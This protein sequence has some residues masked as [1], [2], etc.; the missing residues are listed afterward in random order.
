MLPNALSRPPIT[1]VGSSPAR[2][3]TSA[4]IE[5]VLVLPCAPATA[6]PKRSRIS[7]ASI[8]ARGITGIA[9]VARLDSSGLSGLDRR[10][11]HHDVG[12]A[13]VAARDDPSRTVTPSDSQPIRHRPIASRPIPTPRSRGSRAVRRCRSCR[14]RRCRRSECAAS[15]PASAMH[16]V[17][18]P[19]RAASGRASVA[20]T[21]AHAVAP[22]RDRCASV[23]SSA[24]SRSPVRPRS[25]ITA[26]PRR[27]G[28]TPRRS[29]ADDRRRRSAAAPESPAGPT[30]PVPTAS[31]RPLG[32]HHDV[33]LLHLAVHLVQER[34]HPRARG[35]P[36]RS[37]ADRVQIAL[38][39]LMGDGQPHARG[40][41]LR[42]R[43]HHG[44][45]DRVRAL[46]TA[47]DQTRAH[48]RHSPSAAT[49]VRR[50]PA[51]T[52]L[53]ATNPVRGKNRNAS[54]TF[55]AAA[56]TQR[57]QQPVRDARQR[58]LLE[59]QRRTAA[60]RGQREDRPRREA[61]D[62]D[63]HR[64]PPPREHAPRVH[65][66]PSAAA[67]TRATVSSATCP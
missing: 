32:N 39:R 18:N 35:L 6:M 63:H 45:V 19:L 65:A 60:Q 61:A 17:G 12:V 4:I 53:P 66:P 29:C 50:T 5:V 33:G 9:P 20:R 67:A 31:S 22:R 3:S 36:P 16:L 15:Y 47:N 62:P 23:S 2:S 26:P 10:R 1:A 64:R 57:R 24:A 25:S 21:A 30:P 34:L 42:R 54:G 27:R 58:V 7:S 55:T 56:R 44:H 52:G 51:R 59:Q 13:D 41:Q 37:L 8:S 14:C 46:R 28:Q 11:V 48:A 43:R 40:R 38:T 49:R